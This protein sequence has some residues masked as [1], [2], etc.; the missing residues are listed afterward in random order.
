MEKIM[1]F[2]IRRPRARSVQIVLPYFF[3]QMNRGVQGLLRNWANFL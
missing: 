3:L 2:A 1:T